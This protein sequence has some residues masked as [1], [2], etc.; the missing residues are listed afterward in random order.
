[1]TLVVLTGLSGLPEK[2]KNP[3]VTDRGGQLRNESVK[4]Q[5]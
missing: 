5:E 1:M 3:P 2:E 4:D